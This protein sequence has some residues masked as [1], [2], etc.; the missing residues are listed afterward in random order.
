M[1]AHLQNTLILAVSTLE[2]RVPLLKASQVSFSPF[3]SRETWWVILDVVVIPPLSP[4]RRSTH[5]S[6]VRGKDRIGLAASSAVEEGG[7]KKKNLHRFVLVNTDGKLA[8]VITD[9]V[10]SLR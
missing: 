6:L 7:K 2:E 5:D 10:H 8:A 3:S 9:V 1:L 4:C